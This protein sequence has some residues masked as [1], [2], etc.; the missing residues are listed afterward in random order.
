VIAGNTQPDHRCIS[1]FRRIHLEALAGLY[2]QVLKLCQEMGLVSLGHVALDGTK[3]KAN[4]SKHKAMSYERMQQREDELQAKVEELLRAAEAADTEED[5]AHGEGRRGDELPAELERAEGRRLRRKV[6]AE[7]PFGQIK[8][9]RGFRQFLCV[10]S[11]GSAA[12]GR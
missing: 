1:E 6:I 10:A 9:A 4:A 12:N 2:L 5:R 3:Q 11:P 8:H 7:P